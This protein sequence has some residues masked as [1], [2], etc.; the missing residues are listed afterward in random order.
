M[1][2]A[3][4][5]NTKTLIFSDIH[6]GLRNNSIKRLNICVTVIKQILALVRQ[7][8][9]DTIIFGGDLY[10][11]RQSIDVNTLNIALKCINTLAK[12]CKI[13]LI[14]GNHDTY[15]KNSIDVNSM[16][17]FKENKNIVIV[18]SPKSLEINNQTFLLCPW[19]ADLSSFQK[20]SYDFLVGHFDVSPKFL[21]ASY[22]Q[23]HS[24]TL[25]PSAN[26]SDILDLEGALGSPEVVQLMQE[27]NPSTVS[28]ETQ[29]IQDSVGNFIDVVKKS[30]TIFS[31]HI[32]KH[33]EFVAKHRNFIFIGA[34]NQQTKD[35]IGTKCGCYILD[36]KNQYVFHE[37]EGLPKY[38]NIRL[39]DI[40]KVGVDNFDFSIT[41][42][43]IVCKVYD[44]ELDHLTDSKII[45]KLNDSGIYEELIPDYE[46]NI[47]YGETS[48]VPDESIQLIKKSKLEYIK[49]Y[50]NNIDSS[51]L[52]E[53][54]IDPDKLYTLL[55]NYY[56][57]MDNY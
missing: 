34:T 31:G 39:S 20:E 41:K 37:F 3:K 32:H 38:I 43:N 50:I 42:G 51:I 16:N 15:F 24:K 35:D 45:Q 2:I 47:N 12:Y 4:V 44:V 30:G 18:S 13:Y 33:R 14:V 52:S 5:P 17:I 7:E 22:V 26:I 1:N 25:Q 19:L 28:V 6:F 21:I 27:S 53:Q 10:H 46:V 8:K 48:N 54:K 23:A 57:A 55:Q 29:Q 49:N 40:M 56:I 11:C 36:E 9:I